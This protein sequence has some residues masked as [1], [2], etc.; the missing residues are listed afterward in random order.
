[1]FGVE[2]EAT[3][4]EVGVALDTDETVGSVIPELTLLELSPLLLETPLV[5]VRIGT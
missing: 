4:T 5:D 3:L 1:M 2:S